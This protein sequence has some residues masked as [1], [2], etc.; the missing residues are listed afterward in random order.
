MV[1]HN[2]ELLRQVCPSV[3][4]EG[5]DT[6]RV[7]DRYSF[8]PTTDMLSMLE[9][10]GWRWHKAVQVRPRIRSTEHAKHMIRLRH[11]DLGEQNYAIGDSFPEIL[12]TNAHNGTGTYT[13]RCGVFRLVCSN[14]MVIAGKEFGGIKMRHVGLD[15]SEVNR[16]SQQV[17]ENSNE[18]MN[19]VDKWSDIQLDYWTRKYFAED[20]A[21]LRFKEVNDQLVYSL[22]SSRRSEDESVDLWTT[23][24][25]VQENLL[26]GGYQGPSNRIVKPITSIE[27]D[28]KINS[29]LWKLATKYSSEVSAN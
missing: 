10:E 17:I 26:R 22:L 16:I 28:M 3:F 8:L 5:P 7:S 25:R 15:Q 9:N 24:N 19:R 6:T 18:I 12:L 20:A 1:L 14:G 11:V 23:F 29:E 2:E 4:A 27:K 21:K 13:L